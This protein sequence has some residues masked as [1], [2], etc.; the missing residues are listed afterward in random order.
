MLPNT[1]EIVPMTVI[2]II[3]VVGLAIADLISGGND[4]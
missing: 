1:I 4:E 3:V 2:I